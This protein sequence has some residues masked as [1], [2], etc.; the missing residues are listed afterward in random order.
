MESLGRIL[1]FGGKRSCLHVKTSVESVSADS[2][3]HLHER[4]SLIAFL[5][6]RDGWTAS[7]Y[8]ENCFVK[9][10]HSDIQLLI[11]LLGL[12]SNP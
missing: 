10:L 6:L 4:V 8:S 11:I 3:T 5:S 7:E 1:V 9:R 12:P 2:A